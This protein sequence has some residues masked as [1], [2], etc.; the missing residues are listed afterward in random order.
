MARL[1]AGAMADDLLQGLE[2]AHTPRAGEISGRSSGGEAAGDLA[3]GSIDLVDDAQLERDQFGQFLP[4]VDVVTAAAGLVA[5]SRRARGRGRPLG[6]VNR[7]TRSMPAYMAALGY[8][9]PWLILTEI[10]NADT[11]A[12]ATALRAEPIDVLRA[13][14]QA[15]K[16]LMP[17]H[18]S[19]QPKGLVVD[20]RNL[21]LFVMGDVPPG[22]VEAGR[23]MDLTGADMADDDAGSPDFGAE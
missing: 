14:V 10:A 3:E 2:K 22:D 18:H 12:L 16:E 7:K 11:L 13:R 19:Q 1:M 23:F 15:A 4:G 20:Q 8:K 17:Y 9:D 21:H 5:A 6:A